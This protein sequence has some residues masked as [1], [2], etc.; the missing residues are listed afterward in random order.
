M[1]EVFYTQALAEAHHEEMERDPNVIAIGLD[2]QGLGAAFGQCTGLYE[3][4][5]QERVLT[6]PITESGYTDLGVGVAMGGKR[7]IV[8]IQFAD[9]T[10]YSFDAIVNQAAKM[11]YMSG[12]NYS[13]P[14]VIRAPQGAGFEAAAQHSQSVE[15]WYANVPGLK[16]VMPATPYDAKGLLKAAVRDDD[17]VLF[18]EHKGLMGFKG[19]IPEG[20]YIVPLGQANVV[21]EGSDATIIAIQAMLYQAL[22]AADELAK[23]GINVEIIDPR[24]IIPLDKATIFN[25]VKKTGRAV[26]VH[27]AH[28][29]YGIG[30]E[31]S[32]TITENCFS[33]LKAPVVR[34][35]APN[36]PFSY[37]PSEKYGLPNKDDII[38]AVKGIVKK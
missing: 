17:P 1:K 38:A 24:T 6:M 29:R 3:R 31:I 37:G 34:I 15:S 23:E 22:A 7:P 35:G 25:S 21:K 18:L 26:V 4:F 13:I 16:I 33:Y 12:G 2:L 8:E 36:I 28:V 9:F 10:S 14:I 30:A 32:A 19:D 5:G 11:R 27:E 20:E